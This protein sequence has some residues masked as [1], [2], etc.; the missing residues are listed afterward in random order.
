MMEVLLIAF[1]VTSCI[2]I[3]AI[4]HVLSQRTEARRLAE[5]LKKKLDER[6]VK[7]VVYSDDVIH[8]KIY[9]H[10]KAHYFDSIDE[11]ADDIYN[12]DYLK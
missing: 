6:P 12:K 8:D 4:N 3:L 2:Y 7:I 9:N 1:I 10:I 5:R 11:L